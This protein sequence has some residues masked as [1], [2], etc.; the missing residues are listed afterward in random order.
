MDDLTE[1]QR[2]KNMQRIRSKD[3]K[4]EEIVRKYLFAHGFRYRKNDARYPGKPD[5][6]LPKYKTVIFVNGCF[7]HQHEGC[8][9]A[10]IPKTR[11]EYWLPKLK[12]NK[13]RDRAVVEQLHKSGWR[14][15]IIWECEIRKKADREERLNNLVEL[16][17]GC[18]EADK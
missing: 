17:R 8:R 1:E 12:R 9:Y 18:S 2:K 15:L 7:W 5:I 10:A 6:V 3:T 11:E 13:E 16:I 4:P 14:V